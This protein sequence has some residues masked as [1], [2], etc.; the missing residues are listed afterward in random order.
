M[1]QWLDYKQKLMVK[2]LIAAATLI[3][4]QDAPEMIYYVRTIFDFTML[5]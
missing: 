4:I 1:V 5:A 2:K 3:L